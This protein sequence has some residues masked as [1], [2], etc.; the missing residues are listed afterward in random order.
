MQ[1]DN[2]TAVGFADDTIKQKRSK[3][4]NVCFCWIRDRTSRRQFLVYW[5]PDITNMDNYHTK[6]YLPAHHHLMRSTYLH[7]TEQLANTVIAL[8]LLGCVNPPVR[9]STV[10]HHT[11]K[12]SSVLCRLVSF[13]SHKD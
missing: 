2:S 8:L 12:P 7:P 9:A 10:W 13:L 6:Y 11:V 4:I 5:K 1:V 3:S